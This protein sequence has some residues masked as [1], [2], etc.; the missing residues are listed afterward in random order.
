MMLVGYGV[1]PWHYRAD[2]QGSESN[3]YPGPIPVADIVRRLFNFQV[4]DMPLTITVPASTDDATGMDD[5]GN[6]TKQIV[7]EDFKAIGVPESGKVFFVSKDGY[8]AHQFQEVLLKSVE[9]IIGEETGIGSAGLLRDGAVAFVSVEV[10]ENVMTKE[11]IEFRP[12][13]LASS[14]HDGTLA[15]TY[16]RIVTNVVCDNT[17]HA[18]LAEAGSSFKIKHTKN[19]SLRI[20]DAREALG[21]IH[22]TAESFENYARELVQ[23]PVSDKQWSQF[24]EL[25]VPVKDDASKRALT[26]AD[27]ARSLL[28]GLWNHDNRVTPWRGTGWGVMQAVNTYAHHNSI[29]H[30]GNRLE[31]NMLRAVSGN[32]DKLDT[33]TLGTLRKVLSN[34]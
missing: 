9:K 27:N 22:Q 18:G 28:T 30:G 13:L 7:L 15:L 32:V 24:L 17:M 19:S 5:F 6:P 29:V 21:I 2:S 16:K 14:S 26:M 11:G 25:H 3:L 20:A 23:T 10:P 34:A 31:K 33:D 4:Q 8:Q 1:T 12:K